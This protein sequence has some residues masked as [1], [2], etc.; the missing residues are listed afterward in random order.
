LFAQRQIDRVCSGIH[1]GPA[2]MPTLVAEPLP[3]A[4]ERPT[5]QCLALLA[6]VEQPRE[7]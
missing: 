5:R 3:E 1:S 7:R 2:I 4:L 6:V